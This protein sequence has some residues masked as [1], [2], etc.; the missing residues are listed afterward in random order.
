VPSR[1]I[2]LGTRMQDSTTICDC[3]LPELPSNGSE[4]LR[5][6]RYLS[7]PIVLKRNYLAVDLTVSSLYAY[8]NTNSVRCL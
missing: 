8:E 1:I 2:R 3:C 7:P 5:A 4:A 6:F